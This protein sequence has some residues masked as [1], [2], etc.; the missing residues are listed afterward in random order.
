L[1]C[2]PAWQTAQYKVV[3]NFLQ[4]LYLVPTKPPEE[5]YESENPTFLRFYGEIMEVLEKLNIGTD[6]K[7]CAQAIEDW[8]STIR[9]EYYLEEEA[10]KSKQEKEEEKARKRK[11][12]Q[13]DVDEGQRLADDTEAS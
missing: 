7:V 4:R 8:V 10:R 6:C 5:A 12:E 13:E 9:A 1:K 11:R 2:K 3:S